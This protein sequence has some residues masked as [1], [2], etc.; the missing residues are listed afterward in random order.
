MMDD[1]TKA[2]DTIPS[3]AARNISARTDPG[4]DIDGELSAMLLDFTTMEEP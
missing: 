3:L 1:S 4:N 2:T